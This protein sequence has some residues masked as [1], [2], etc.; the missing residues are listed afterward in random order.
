[1]RHRGAAPH[2]EES[3]RAMN[4]CVYPGCENTRRTRGLCHNHYQSMRSRVRDGRVTEASL[5]ERGLLLPKGTG[6][7]SAKDHLKAFEA[8]STVKGDAYTG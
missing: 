3:K 2:T 4:Q 7:C 8:D 1:M 5:E 6:G